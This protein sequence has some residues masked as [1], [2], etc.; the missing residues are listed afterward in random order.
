MKSD[1]SEI[2]QHLEAKWGAR[3]CPMCGQ[4]NWSFGNTVFELRE[5]YG[6]IFT[7]ARG[8]IVPVIPIYCVNCGLTI[9]INPIIAKIK[10][11][12]PPK[13]GKKPKKED[14]P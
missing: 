4:S 12:T 13:E 10:F 5:Y 8:P 1:P 7:V 9:L 6:E 2:M 11:E 14:S 3:K